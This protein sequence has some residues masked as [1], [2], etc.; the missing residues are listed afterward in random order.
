[1]NGDRQL[2][3]IVRI[4]HSGHEK[5]ITKQLT[6]FDSQLRIWQLLDVGACMKH[7]CKGR[8]TIK[9]MSKSKNR[10]QRTGKEEV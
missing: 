10:T 4:Q 2:V 7:T 9:N 1:L 8:T 3:G 5:G 6:G